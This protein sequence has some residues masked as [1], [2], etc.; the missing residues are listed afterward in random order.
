MILDKFRINGKVAIVTGSR[1]G[2]GKGCALSLAEAGA[3]IVITN[4]FGATAPKLS[5]YKLSDRVSEINARAAEVA[6]R[7]CPPDKFVAGDIG[8]TG[9]MLKPYGAAEEAEVFAAFEEQ[10]GALADGGVDLFIIET[11]M[12]LREALLAL[13]ATKSHNLPTLACMTFDK[14]PRGYFTMMG[15]NSKDVVIALAEAGADAVGANCSLRIKDMIGLVS[16]IRAATSL[17]IV[18]EPNAGSPELEDGKP[19]YI[20]GPE[21]IGEM[22]PEL[23]AAGARIIGG[24]CGTGP[25]TIRE[26]RRTID[27]L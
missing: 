26:I 20:D 2:L 22:I 15:N 1:R 17:P 10:A 19:K 23:I 5:H 9:L 4:T 3:D 24:C 21:A 12:D 7:V 11:M 25:D 27:R 14:K 18:A 8:P 13:K 6:R 16:E